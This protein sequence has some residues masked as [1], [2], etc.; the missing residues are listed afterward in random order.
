MYTFDDTSTIRGSMTDFIRKLE[1]KVKLT[2][3]PLLKH[4]FQ[5]LPTDPL[6]K[7]PTNHGIKLAYSQISDLF[8]DIHKLKLL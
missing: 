2:P 4:P 6:P 1:C 3:I 5:Q 8:V 7:L